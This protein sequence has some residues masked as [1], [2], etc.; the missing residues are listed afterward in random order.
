MMHNKFAVSDNSL[1]LTGSANWTKNANQ[2]DEN[3]VF[4]KGSAVS[5]QFLFKFHELK[6]DTSGV[7]VPDSIFE[8]YPNLEH[9]FEKDIID[10]LKRNITQTGLPGNG[11]IGNI[12]NEQVDCLLVDSI[13]VD[14]IRNNYT[15]EAV[16]MRGIRWHAGERNLGGVY[17]RHNEYLRES[18][19]EKYFEEIQEA[20]PGLRTY[21][22]LRAISR[23]MDRYQRKLSG[24]LSEEHETRILRVFQYLL[25]ERNSLALPLGI[26]IFPSGWGTR[27]LPQ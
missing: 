3:L 17:T 7:V 23:V 11:E 21:F 2:N 13:I 16:K 6:L 14:R 8:I 4:I 27:T 15:P 19:T 5:I 26:V 20:V 24:T 12:E 18:F 1:L 10:C 25:K 22:M 9:L